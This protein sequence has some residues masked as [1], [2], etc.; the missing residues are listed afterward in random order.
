LRLYNSFLIRCWLVSDDAAEEEQSVV[1]IEHIQ[2]GEHLRPATIA[3]AEG[4]MCEAQ[5]RSRSALKSIV[6]MPDG[7]EEKEP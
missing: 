6:E 7:V 3:E 2:T 1:D 5:R 4:W